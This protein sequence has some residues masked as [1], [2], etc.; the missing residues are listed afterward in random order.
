ML[1]HKAAAE[2]DKKLPVHLQAKRV[3]AI[4]LR[5]MGGF[6]SQ[7]AAPNGKEAAGDPKMRMSRLCTCLC[8]ACG[9]DIIHS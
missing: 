6:P 8:A 1:S 2:C 9:H 4:S 7:K 5:G 3:P